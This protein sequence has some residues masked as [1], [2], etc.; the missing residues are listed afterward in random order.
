LYKAFLQASSVRYSGLALSN[1]SPTEL[2]HDSISRWLKDRNFR[3][4]DVKQTCGIERCQS[5]T[6]RAQRNHI[7]MAIMAWFDKHRRRIHEQVSFYK[8]DWEMIKP[9]ISLGIKTIMA[10]SA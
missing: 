10:S 8:Q 9:G 5:R 2:S 3:P 6:G 7:F 1:V 4:R